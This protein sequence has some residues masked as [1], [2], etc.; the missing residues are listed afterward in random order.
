MAIDNFDPYYDPSQK[1]RNVAAASRNSA[2][3]LLEIDVRNANELHDAFGTFKPDLVVHLAAKAGVRASVADP[4]SYLQVNELGGLNILQACVK[5]GNT[6]L[7]FASTSSVYGSSAM[8]PFSEDDCAAHPL[9]PYAA[10]KRASELMVHSFHHIHQ[11]PAAI[12]RFFTVYGPRGR[13]DMAM[14]L[15][16]RALREGRTIRIHGED[17]ARDF[18]YVDDIVDGVMG[19]IRWVRETRGFGT[20]N[21]GRAEPVNVRRFVELLAAQVNVVPNIVL[22]ELQPGES[23][24]TAANVSRAREALGYSPKVTLEEGIRGWL[25]WLDNSE[26]APTIEQ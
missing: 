18:T 5:S 14:H 17:T 24:V 22:G 13:P 23:P 25:T 4:L 19:A 3:Q 12:L 11:Q 8:P 9:S 21:L 7:V 15:F 10:S 6:P 1:R 20:F 26:E 16:T 2:Y